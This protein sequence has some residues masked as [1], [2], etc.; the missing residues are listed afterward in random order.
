MSTTRRFIPVATPQLGQRD[1]EL[2]TEAVR[3]RVISGAGGNFLERFEREFAAYCGCSHGLATSSGTTA[4]HLAVAALGIGPGDEVLVSTLTFMSSFFAVL[5]QGATPIPV[6]IE[7]H[8][9]N[10]NPS[11]L[12][13]LITPRTKAILVVHLYGHP[14]D[15]DP[16]LELA[17]RHGLYVIEDAAEAHGA[18]YRGRKVGGL[19]DVACFS[20]YANKIV[21]TGEGGMVTTNNLAIADR[22]RSLRSLA[23]GSKQK[24]MHTGIGFNYRMTNLQAALGCAQLEKIEEVIKGKRRVARLYNQHL[25]GWEGIKL[26]REEPYAKSVFWM[27]HIV[28]AGAGA[29]CRDS[30]I[31]KL[32][33][34]GIEAKPTFIPFNKQEAFIRQGLTRPESCPIAN[35]VAE[36][37]LYLPTSPDLTEDD[38]SYVVE[39]LG[40][41]LGQS[42]CY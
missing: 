41:A 36:S 1:L 40:T 24:F 16:V 12:E 30:V 21:T 20:F 26:P 2:V 13:K 28:L 27:Y 7:E 39:T 25:S 15:M 19:G 31:D 6:D 4:L 8:T 33:E 9:W 32:R 22:V 23:Y 17:R 38:I 29:N 3:G 18:L 37:G 14:V 35:R 42:H 11:L 10:I 5:Y 34:C